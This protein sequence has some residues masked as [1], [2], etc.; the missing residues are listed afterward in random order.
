MT[1]EDWFTS[2]ESF[3]QLSQIVLNNGMALDDFGLPKL[4]KAMSTFEQG[5]LA[6]HGS[7]FDPSSSANARITILP[8]WRTGLSFAT[9]NWTSLHS[10][11]LVVAAPLGA[12][13]N[14]FI[15]RIDG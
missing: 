8:S 11:W 13:F 12:L 4:M 6:S 3:A 15:G 14:K 5:Y 1:V 2:G 10:V 7:A 9:T